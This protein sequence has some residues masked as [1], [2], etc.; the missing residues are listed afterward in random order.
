MIGAACTYLLELDIDNYK[1]MLR[2]DS[3][4]ESLY[5]LDAPIAFRFNESF[6][7]AE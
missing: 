1:K 3:V 6:A 7:C 2:N 4:S 5:S